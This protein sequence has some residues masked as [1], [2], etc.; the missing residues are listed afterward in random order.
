MK[1][2]RYTVEARTRALYCFENDC[3]CALK[4]HSAALGFGIMKMTSA[5]SDIPSWTLSF[6]S[7][8]LWWRRLPSESSSS[9]SLSLRNSNQP[10]PHNL[11]RRL[12]IFTSLLSSP[13]LCFVHFYI[14]FFS[15]PLVSSLRPTLWFLHIFRRNQVIST[16]TSYKYVP[17]NALPQIIPETQHFTNEYRKQLSGVL[18]ILFKRRILYIKINLMSYS[19]K[20]W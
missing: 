2:I 19:R 18:S 12:Y 1:E 11:S 7:V 15:S 3:L 17:L 4:A 20:R 6:V 16:E 13:C 5:C 10:P 8:A 9:L 14:T